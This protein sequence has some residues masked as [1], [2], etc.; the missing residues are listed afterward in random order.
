M[1]QGED[2]LPTC[3]GL[4]KFVAC[5]AVPIV[6]AV[7]FACAWLL[8]APKVSA[9]LYDLIGAE[10]ARIP[11]FLREASAADVSIVVSS[12]DADKARAVATALCARYAPAPELPP[13]ALDFLRANR[14][15]LVTDEAAELLQTP[16]GRTKLARRAQRRL[17]TSP[18]P[19]VLGFADDPFGLTDAF[20]LSLP[21]AR[22]AKSPEG[23]PMLVTNGITRILLRH[24]LDPAVAADL[25]RTIVF[26]AAL[27][28][29]LASVASPDVE[30]RAAGAPVHAA[31]SAARSKGEIG[32]L[33]WF[34]VA[35]I[36][37][38]SLVVFRSARWLPLLAGSLTVSALSGGIALVAAC[39]EIHV[40]TFVMGTTVLGLV[41][42]YSFHWLLSSGSDKPAVRRNLFVSFLT[43]EISLVPLMLATIPVLRQSALFLGVGLAAAFGYVVTCYPVDGRVAR[44]A[45]GASP[46]CRRAVRFLLA[47]VLVPLALGVFRSEFRTDVTA[48]YRP[49]AD[50][51]EA[52]RQ[53]AAFGT[54]DLSAVPSCAERGVRAKNV[55]ILYAEH[56]VAMAQT[57]QLPTLVPPPAPTEEL[58]RPQALMESIFRTW[59]KDA[60]VRFVISVLAIFLALVVFRRRRAGRILAP[61]LVALLAVAGL[62]GWLRMPVNV[63]HVLAAFLLL[64]MG[65]DYA[66]FLQEGG[67]AAV[68]PAFCSLLTSVAGFGALAFV[69][70]PV[71]RSFGVVL[72]VGLPVSFAMALLLMPSRAASSEAPRGESV[73]HGASLLGMETLW[74]LYRIFGLR[75]LHAV[76]ALVGCCVWT[77]SPA[78]R[79]A[80]PSARKVV[81]FTRSLSDKLVV[82]AE[83]LRL[84]RV[85]TDASPDAKAFVDDVRAGKGVF[86]LSS[87]VGTIEVLT[88]LGA[89]D[90]TFHAWMDFDRTGVFNRFYLRHARRRRVV[91][92]PISDFGLQTVFEAGACIDAGDCLVMA[93]DRG[94]GAFRFAAAFDHPVY[95]VACVAE[96]GCRYR[97]IIRRLPSDRKAMAEAYASALAELV[98]GHPAQHFVW[99]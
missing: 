8:R 14:G 90:R 32:V 57:L 56:G 61:S 54:F 25:D 96:G 58:M 22:V 16:A 2:A 82:M 50:L 48:L 83:G 49:P 98:R 34:S 38:L 51:L 59:T 91:I 15:G 93:G 63:F 26:Q 79:H 60:L 92:H 72:G 80:S 43:T 52:E 11:S 29:D 67:P 87:H 42:D 30:A 39:G 77:F 65:V 33:T 41:I 13:G 1:M 45:D 10:S 94:A 73:E 64:G 86:V 17:F 4:L 18:L 5:L 84:P 27:A 62:L 88:A 81:A 7:V 95:F 24:R 46:R 12:A 71:V 97:A 3:H 70:F 78:V 6:L 53:R 9:S 37:L 44:T 47:L 89:C 19:P 23:W 40:M 28:H 66:V 36:V 31:V 69:S 74:L 55:R 20:L 21:A 99:A 68:R 35:V 76:S 75:F 85:E